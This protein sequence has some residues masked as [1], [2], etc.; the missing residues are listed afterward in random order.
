MIN[1]SADRLKRPVP[2]APLVTFRVLFGIM[3][4]V[5]TIRFWLNG[6]I[7]QQFVAP[8]FYFSYM[9]FEWVKPLGYTG[10]HL[11][12]ALIALATV[13]ITIG[14]F[15]R[16][17]TVVFFL[18]FTYVEL[19]D[20][21]NYLN[22]YYFICL[23]GFMLIWL[24]A[25]RSWSVD[26]KIW[27]QL[28]RTEV[29][30]WMVGVLRLQVA[31]VYFFAGLAK[32]NPDWL[33][34]AIPMK[35]WLPAKSHLPL[36]GQLMYTTW[37][38]Y[39][40]SWFGAV[41]DL[42]IAFFLINKKTRPYAYVFVL[43]FHIATAIFFPGIGLFPYVMMVVSTIF[44]SSDA[45]RKLLGYFN[46]GAKSNPQPLRCPQKIQQAFAVG[47]GVYFAIQI[48]VPLRFIAYPSGL[49]WHE[50]GFRFSWRVML[51]EKS[52][53]SFFTV[54]EPSTG[55]EYE[56]NNSEFLTPLQEKMMSTQPDMIL[57]YAHFLATTYEKRGLKHPAVY[58]QCFVALNG[59]RSRP[60]INSA[61]NLAVQ[62]LGWQ[63]Y[64]WVLPLPTNEN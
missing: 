3:M 30:L 37:I 51:M 60:F 11:L 8:K 45:H 1:L 52:G 10:M 36:I 42:F 27:P 24:P 56:V 5:G 57:R 16:V 64:K 13:F 21:T 39:L 22:H 47:I 25:H 7:V 48:I 55:K 17:A 29:P 23:V 19:I 31:I 54:K 20:I 34:N 58:A 53:N 2:I 44:F 63:H 18:A 32:L 59:R 4:L 12:F 9:G 38:A 41:Y 28:K 49:F 46:K 50:E 14:F 15:Y 61:T 62:Q 43:G 40:F 6:W 26:V 35:I 33:L